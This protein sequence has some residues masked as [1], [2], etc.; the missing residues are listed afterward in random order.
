[1]KFV[2]NDNSAHRSGQGGD[3]WFDEL[4]LCAENMPPLSGPTGVRMY[5]LWYKAEGLQFRR[6]A[7]GFGLIRLEC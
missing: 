2:W 3:W 1:V 5:F 4:T 7:F 6:F